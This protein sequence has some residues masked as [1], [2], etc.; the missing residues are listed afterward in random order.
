MQAFFYAKYIIKIISLK[1]DTAA[2]GKIWLV[3]NELYISTSKPGSIVRIH[4][5]DGVLLKQQP[6]LQVM[7]LK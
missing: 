6:I 5:M 4:S 7:S 1:T 2:T 3:A